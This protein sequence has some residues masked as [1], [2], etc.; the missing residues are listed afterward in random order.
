MPKRT[1]E[2]LDQL[3]SLGFSDD[4]FR[5]I[6]HMASTSIRSTRIYCQK[7]EAFPGDGANEV[8]RERLE[9]VLALF[10]AGHFTEPAKPG[11]FTGLAQAALAEIP[12]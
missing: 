10:E 3:C 1:I 5:V 2:L 6:H 7:I 11:V 4:D 8:V 12:K 9:L